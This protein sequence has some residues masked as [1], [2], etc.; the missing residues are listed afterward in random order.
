MKLSFQNEEEQE[1]KG[2]DN[3]SVIIKQGNIIIDIIHKF[4]YHTHTT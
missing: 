1:E 4:C 2:L 3:K